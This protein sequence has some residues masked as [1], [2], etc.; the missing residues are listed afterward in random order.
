MAKIKI[1]EQ[2]ILDSQRKIDQMITEANNSFDS[3]FYQIKINCAE[4]VQE[5]LDELKELISK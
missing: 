5:S 1:L 3:E 2:F 4:C